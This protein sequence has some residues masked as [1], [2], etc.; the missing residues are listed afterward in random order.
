MLVDW[1]FSEAARFNLFE[2]LRKS[3]PMGDK[4]VNKRGMKR[5]GL[6]KVSKLQVQ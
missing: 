3:P 4:Q 6:L 1:I 2:A 5:K